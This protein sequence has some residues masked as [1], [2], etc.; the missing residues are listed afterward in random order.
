VTKG[1]YFYY[2]NDMRT[3]AG[4]DALQQLAKVLHQLHVTRPLIIVST[5]VLNAGLVE[6]ACKASGIKKELITILDGIPIGSSTEVVLKMAEA[7]RNGDHDGII[8]IGGGSVI[9][10]AKAVNLVVSQKENPDLDILRISTGFRNNPIGPGYRRQP[11]VAIPTTFG[12][13]SGGSQSAS[14]HSAR[15]GRRMLFSFP[16]LVP[17]TTILDPQ[18]FRTLTPVMTATGIITALSLAIESITSLSPN[19]LSVN[20]ATRAVSILFRTALQAILT[21][22]D[23]ELRL[24]LAIAS[25]LAGM[26]SSQSRG[27]VTL[28]LSN[29]LGACCGIPYGNCAFILL[30]YALEYNLH[31]TIGMLA[32]L[33]RDTASP[34][35]AEIP[36]PDIPDPAAAELLLEKVK[37]LITE[38]RQATGNI[39]PLRFFDLQDGKGNRVI[40]SQQFET[41]AMMASGDSSILFSKEELDVQDLIRIIEASYWGYPLDRDVIRKGHQKKPFRETV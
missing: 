32:N 8:A 10:T 31:A 11:L 33:Y 41:I 9:D 38:L 16:S 5:S 7:Y 36:V 24:Q 4:M 29:S 2:A 28:A 14:V 17:N 26:A 20:L 18:M 3:I 25:H 15:T 12:P 37:I 35:A 34:S 30:P 21:P 6:S 13:G 19:P 39:T 40:E 22:F 27:S 23:Q 1:S